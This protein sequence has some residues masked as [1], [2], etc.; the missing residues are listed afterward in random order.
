M[1][2]V[3]FSAEKTDSTEEP[4]RKYYTVLIDGE[5]AGD[6]L[7]T[8]GDFD[9]IVLLAR[10]AQPYAEQVLNAV[11]RRFSTKNINIKYYD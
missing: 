9:V 10:S 4:P 6:A 3:T 11:A 8:Q 1:V 2:K 7:P 5:E